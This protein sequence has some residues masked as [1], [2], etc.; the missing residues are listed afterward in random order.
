MK[1]QSKPDRLTVTP[2]RTCQSVNGKLRGETSLRLHLQLPLTSV[3][4]FLC[5]KSKVVWVF[6]KACYTTTCHIWEC[7]Q[8]KSREGPHNLVTGNVQ[9]L[10]EKLA[11]A[12]LASAFNVWHDGSVGQRGTHRLYMCAGKSS[13]YKLF[14][15]MRTRPHR[16]RART[17]PACFHPKQMCL[18]LLPSLNLH[19]CRNPTPAFDSQPISRQIPSQRLIQHQRPH[20]HL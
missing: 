3:N 6:S 12:S 17:D 7:L 15:C 2:S 11:R 18:C 8:K 16:G 20:R 5:K 10:S 19:N 4:W 14:S 1:S 13:R 9:C